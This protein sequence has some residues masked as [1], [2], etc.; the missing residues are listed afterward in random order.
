MLIVRFDSGPALRAAGFKA[1]KKKSV[2]QKS[3]TFQCSSQ[4]TTEL[5]CNIDLTS[6]GC[7]VFINS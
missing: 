5:K 6:S 3:S 2:L 4:S 7:N 1:H